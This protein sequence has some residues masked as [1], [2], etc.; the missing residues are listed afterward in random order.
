VLIHGVLD[1]SVVRSKTAGGV[2]PGLFLPDCMGNPYGSRKTTLNEY[3]RDFLCTG[4]HG[5]P[6]PEAMQLGMAGV[7][8]WCLHATG[9]LHTTPIYS[10]AH[11]APAARKSYVVWV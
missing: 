5:S 11:V 9:P 6:E 10:E 4:S 7:A 8:C 1:W 2:R 3:Y